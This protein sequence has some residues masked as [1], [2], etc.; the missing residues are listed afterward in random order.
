MAYDLGI[1]ARI[2]PSQVIIKRQEAGRLS[3]VE[4]LPAD[5]APVL[6]RPHQTRPP[7]A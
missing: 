6:D 4:V 3:D 5:W 7:S 1:D 2:R